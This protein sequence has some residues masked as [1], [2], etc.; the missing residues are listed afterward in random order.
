NSGGY[1]ALALYCFSPA[2]VVQAA[3]IG[4]V[5]PAGWGIFGTIF[6]AIAVSHNL[7]APWKQWRYRTL[8]LSIATALAVA[9]HPAAIAAFPAAV[10]F[11]IYLAPGRRLVAIPLA[12]ISAAIAA[13][14]IFFAYSF[15]PQALWSGLY[16]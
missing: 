14:L 12:L 3:Q 4:E 5:V 9:S 13:A 1:I 2:M 11:M 8:L 7:Y 15:E 10:A 6:G 16:L